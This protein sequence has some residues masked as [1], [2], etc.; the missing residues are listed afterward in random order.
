[1]DRVLELYTEDMAELTEIDFLE[2]SVL[3][4]TNERKRGRQ[5]DGRPLNLRLFSPEQWLSFF[6]FTRNEVLQ[7]II[8]LKL[9]DVII[10]AN[11]VVE[12]VETAMTMMLS[13][14]AWP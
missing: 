2:A 12:D 8:A 14:L 3:M 7:L 11:G 13:Q 10:G 4:R 5:R 6:R 1:M 9:P